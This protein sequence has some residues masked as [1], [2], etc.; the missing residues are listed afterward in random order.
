MKLMYF[1]TVNGV[2]YGWYRL[3]VM[4]CVPVSEAEYKRL[5]GLNRRGKKIVPNANGFPQ[6]VDD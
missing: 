1:G 4:R 2:D 5:M 3:P 6:A